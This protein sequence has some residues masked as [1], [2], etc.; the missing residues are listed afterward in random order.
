[1][2]KYPIQLDV[3][4]VIKGKNPQTKPPRFFISLLEKI[5][6]QDELNEVL[7]YAGDAEG[8]LFAEKALEYFNIRLNPIGQE[9][10]PANGQ[11][12][13]V[14]NHP[15][16]GLDGIAL[17]A[18][19]G[20]RFDGKINVPV[21]DFLMHVKNLEPIFLPVNKFGAQTKDAVI[22]TN[23]AYLSE[24][25]MLI[26][27]AGFCSRRQHGK[28]EDLKWKKTFI[29]KAVEYNRSIIPIYFNELNSNFFYNLSAIRMK[30]GIKANIESLFL[31]SEM[32]KKKNTTFTF[33]IG[34]PIPPTRFDKSKTPQQ[35]AEYVK[36]AVYN[37]GK[38][39]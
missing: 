14:S 25:Q 7:K 15:L 20:S 30:L 10:I 5:I 35:W 31:P 37:L 9:N 13:F 1:M 39:L 17:A 8:S 3:E 23:E 6:H 19:L 28:I 36:E 27:P 26:F 4:K 33:Y 21:N 11:F 32:F 22:K 34:K 16:G 2:S 12:I 38:K 24:N 29:N 18:F